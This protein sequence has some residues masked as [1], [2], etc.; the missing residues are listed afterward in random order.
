VTERAL[1]ARRYD[2]KSVLVTGGTGF[3]GTHLSRRLVAYGAEVVVLGRHAGPLPDGV[4]LVLGDVRSEAS[5]NALIGRGFDHVFNLAA[6]SGQ[7][8]SF[9]DHEQ[10]LT[11]N[12]LGHLNLLEAI[13][14]LSPDTAMCFASSRL[15]YGRTRY[16][17]VDEDHPKEACS[18]YG[19]HKRTCEEYCEYYAL[20]FGVRSV[21]LR[22]A[23]P[24]GPHHPAGHH[25]YNIANWMIDE[26]IAGREATVFGRGEQLRD[27]IYIDD[28][29]DAMLCAAI[30]RKAAGRVY[31]VGSGSGT[32]LVDFVQGVIGVA[33]SG[34]YKLTE[35]PQEFL[36]VETGD[37]AADI[38][39]IGTEL[40]WRPRVSLRDG[41]A[42]TVAASGAAPKRDAAPGRAAAQGSDA[43]PEQ[44]A[45]TLKRAA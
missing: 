4:E 24:Y 5:V 41:I 35:W 31:N 28:A 25:R 9:T 40:G 33:G 22:I 44:D 30:D 29:V 8:P 10:S 11:T 2:G 38:S 15:V 45:E 27:Y 12:C 26:L 17:P 34:S 7:V 39:R 13:R 16:L 20:R 18:F 42:M 6:Y 19:I 23:N 32:A 37:Y 36:Q 3:I 1:M 21:A 14:S 43:E